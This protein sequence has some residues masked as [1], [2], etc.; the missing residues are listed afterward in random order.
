MWY[1]EQAYLPRQQ[2]KETLTTARPEVARLVI[3]L[4]VQSGTSSVSASVCTL[5]GRDRGSPASWAMRGALRKIT[6]V[7]TNTVEV[8]VQSLRSVQLVVRSRP[9]PRN[10]AHTSPT[11][12]AGVAAHGRLNRESCHRSSRP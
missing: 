1:L 5:R 2:S 6:Q 8:C 7:V 3:L 10:L 12:L 9:L 4:P 11:G